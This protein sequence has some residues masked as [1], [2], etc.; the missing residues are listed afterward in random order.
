[1]RSSLCE[2]RVH[3][4]Q[5]THTFLSF[6]F[7]ILTYNLRPSTNRF[8]PKIGNNTENNHLY[9]LRTLQFTNASRFFYVTWYRQSNY[10][11]CPYTLKIILKLRRYREIAQITKL[12]EVMARLKPRCPYSKDR[13]LYHSVLLLADEWAQGEQEQIDEGQIHGRR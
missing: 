7:F 6:L 8:K 1:M 4:H 3:T 13:A 2:H 10:Y 12:I 11:Y 9:S 5:I